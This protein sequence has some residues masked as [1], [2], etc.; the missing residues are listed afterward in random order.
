[1][2]YKTTIQVIAEAENKHEAMEIVGEYL[3]GNIAS[4]IEMRYST[5]EVTSHSKVVVSIFVVLF[6]LAAGLF[7]TVYLKSPQGCSM[8]ASGF[9]AVQPPLKT[10]DALKNGSGFKAEWQKKQIDEALKRI[11]E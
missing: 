7:S 5:K 10:H 6:V 4:G 9:N 11:K 8:P 2:K 1:M 3:S